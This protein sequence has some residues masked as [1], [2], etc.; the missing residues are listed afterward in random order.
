MAVLS[1]FLREQRWRAARP[2]LRGAVLDLG[3]SD[4]WLAARL[5]AEQAYLGVERSPDTIAWLEAHY[6]GR[7]FL[8]RDLDRDDLAL[9]ERFDTIVLLAILE[10]LRDPDRVLRQLAGCL[11]PAGRVVLTTPTP[12]GD[13]VHQIG[14]RLGL[15]SRAAMDEHATIFNRASLEPRLERNGLRLVHYRTFLLGGNQLGVAEAAR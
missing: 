3:C 7:R 12:P 5:P 13:R 1:G 6:P 8:R 4:G 2:Y 14:A 9:T 15:F 11:R 10:H